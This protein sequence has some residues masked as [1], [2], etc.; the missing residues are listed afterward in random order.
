MKSLNYDFKYPDPSR[1]NSFMNNYA[2]THRTLD[3]PTPLN[4]NTNSNSNSNNN[5]QTSSNTNNFGN[6]MS[7]VYWMLQDP[8]DETKY[9]YN[10]SLSEQLTNTQIDLYNRAS[11]NLL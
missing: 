9:F 11:I 3:S 7:S 5:G 8:I 1:S 10:K 6:S 4:I 2:N